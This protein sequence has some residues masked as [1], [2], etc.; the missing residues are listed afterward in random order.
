MRRTHVEEAVGVAPVVRVHEEH[1]E[2]V[3]RHRREQVER[4][5][6]AQ[7]VHRNRAR[8]HH[9]LVAALLQDQTCARA[10][11][12]YANANEELLGPTL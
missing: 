3:H 7:V 9:H 8:L 11:E 5:P 6:R 2:V 1:D 4:E 10:P 12:Q